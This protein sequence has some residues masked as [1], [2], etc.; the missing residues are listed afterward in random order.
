VTTVIGGNILMMDRKL[1]SLNEKE[2]MIKA[3]ERADALWKRF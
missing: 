1:T 3:R 2:I